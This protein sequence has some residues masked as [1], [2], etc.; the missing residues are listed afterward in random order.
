MSSDVTCA[1]DA[2]KIFDPL[3]HSDFRNVSRA[4]ATGGDNFPA[5]ELIHNW[6][7]E[8]PRKS[9]RDRAGCNPWAAGPVDRLGS[10]SRPSAIQIMGCAND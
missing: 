4:Q 3:F 1:R 6:Q 5:C 2:Q 9:R 7:A 8:H 10:V